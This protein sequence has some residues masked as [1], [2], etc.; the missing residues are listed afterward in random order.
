[1]CC[2]WLAVRCVPRAAWCLFG[3]G[4]LRGANCLIDIV[5]SRLFACC[6][7][8]GVRSVPL[9]VCYMVFVG[10]CLMVLG[11]C[12]CCV[13]SAMV[14]VRWSLCVVCCRGLG[15]VRRVSSIV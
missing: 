7:R 12:V 1:M 11:C 2:V 14:G 8:V 6:V 10:C 9:A 5:W 4:L 3:L 13:L 15:V